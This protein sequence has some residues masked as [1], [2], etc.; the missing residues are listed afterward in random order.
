MIHRQPAK[1]VAL[2]L[3]RTVE[4]RAH[5]LE[6]YGRGQV[7]DL[8]RIKMA[9]EVLKNIV[10]NID[11][12][13]RHLLCI[14]KRGALSGRK[15]WILSILR[16]CRELLFAKSDTAATGSVDVDSKDAADHLRRAQTDHSLQ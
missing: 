5:I 2:D 15:Q 8:L 16:Q 7:H 12:S 13:Q 10:G 11:G 1:A 14:A 4:S 3:Q 6:R 9:L